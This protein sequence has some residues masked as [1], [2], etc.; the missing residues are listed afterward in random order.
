[1]PNLT[2]GPDV[3]SGGG[4]DGPGLT[5][6]KGAAANLGRQRRSG[7]MRA[8]QQLWL[9]CFR[10]ECLVAGQHLRKIDPAQRSQMSCAAGSRADTAL[11]R[12]VRGSGIPD[13]AHGLRRHIHMNVQHKRLVCTAVRTSIRCKRCTR[14]TS[15]KLT[16]KAG[17]ICWLQ[18]SEGAK[19]SVT[20]EGMLINS[21][22][23]SRQHVGIHSIS[24]CSCP[25]NMAAA[26]V[27][28]PL[29]ADGQQHCMQ[30]KLQTG[31]LRSAPP[32]ILQD[33]RCRDQLPP[34]P[35]SYRSVTVLCLP[36]CGASLP[37]PASFSRT[38][39]VRPFP[40]HSSHL[41]APCSFRSSCEPHC[42]TA[43]CSTSLAP[44]HSP[45]AG[46]PA[47]TRSPR[48][49]PPGQGEQHWVTHSFCSD[50]NS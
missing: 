14:K 3:F 40:R 10:F 46:A 32:Q 16:F 36:V 35:W 26:A 27:Q 38:S 22:V 24:F 5:D 4:M 48:H 28:A 43:G 19:A 31:M 44:A 2:S 7:D 33:S 34:R 20:R 8:P 21:W 9:A 17:M 13:I 11:W 49:R 25:V 18:Q 12:D 30:R 39:H 41:R 37:T 42:R 50:T 15:E 47:A 1:M 23:R 6:A 45:G 29:C